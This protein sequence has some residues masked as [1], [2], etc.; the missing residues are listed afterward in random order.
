[1][2][3]QLINGK[4]LSPG[5]RMSRW[6]QLLFGVDHLKKYLGLTLLM[7]LVKKRNL[8]VYWNKRFVCLSTPYFAKVM[9]QNV[10]QLISQFLHCSDD[11]R[12]E[13]QHD[14]ERYGP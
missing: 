2:Q 14:S 13:A 4:D 3:N 12:P 11:T 5:S 6:E 9:S 8:S 1:M 7:G 10:C